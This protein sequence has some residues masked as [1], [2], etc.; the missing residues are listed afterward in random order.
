MTVSP[1]L[2]IIGL[3]YMGLHHL[4]LLTAMKEDNLVPGLT[5]MGIADPDER[6]LDEVQSKYGIP[7]AT[8]RPDELLADCSINTVIIASPT[9]CHKPQVERA[10]SSGKAVYCEKPLC[11]TASESHTLAALAD[12]SNIPNQAGLVLRHLPAID[13]I[14]ELIDSAELGAPTHAQ[15]RHDAYTSFKSGLYRTDWKSSMEQS[16]GGILKEANVHDIDILTYLLGDCTVERSSV[17]SDSS[18][19][20]T[21]A[22]AELDFRSGAEASFKTFWHS[23]E[24]RPTTRRLEIFCEKGFVLADDFMFSDDVKYQMSGKRMQIMEKKELY[25]CCPVIS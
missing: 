15:M 19:L 9:I 6:Q 8:T 25:H 3:G 21:Y 1:S 7:I 24:G 10:L 2:G 12:T 14:K 17:T 20:D 23:I 13:F 16:G 22:N 5:I 18:R 4:K 11:I